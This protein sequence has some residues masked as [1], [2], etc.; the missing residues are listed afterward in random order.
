MTEES[1]SD[2][3][4]S[5]DDLPI[6]IVHSRDV[7]C[8]DGKVEQ[9]YRFLTYRFKENDAE[10]V[11]RVYFDDPWRISITA[12]MFDA[13]IPDEVLLYMKRRFRIITQLGGADGYAEIWSEKSES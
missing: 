4:T 11:A 5:D 9:D 10:I 1:D 3:P 2:F 12:P 6:S 13:P 7:I 8:F